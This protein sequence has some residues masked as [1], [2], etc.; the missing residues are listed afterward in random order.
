MRTPIAA[1]AAALVLPITAWAQDATDTTAPE[2]ELTTPPIGTTLD[3]RRVTVSGTATDDVGVTRVLYRIE[4]S[5]K[6]RKAVL[7]NAGEGTTTF[8]FNARLPK[9]GHTRIY[10]RAEDEAG[11]ESDT[12]GRKYSIGPVPVVVP[13]P[14]DG[15]TGGN[16]GNGAGGF[17]PTP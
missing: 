16:G 5:R 3:S 9:R 15:G 17:T 10:V 14:A 4:R 1:L 12:I 8:V 7:T 2:V 13:A 6:W 11:N